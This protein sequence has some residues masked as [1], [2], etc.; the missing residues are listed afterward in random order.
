[1]R[2]HED[3]LGSLEYIVLLA[4]LRVGVDAYGM[5]VRRE[6][7]AVAGRDLS[8][9]AVY[10]TLVRM[11][12]KGYL[13]SYPGQATAERGGRAK[14]HYCATAKGIG[15]VRDMREVL[16]KMGEGVEGIRGVS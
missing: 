14:R 6:I 1:M 3:A 2:T 9:G 12:S 4:V 11:E 5:T 7:L 8:I 10:T 15:A 16:N 13:R